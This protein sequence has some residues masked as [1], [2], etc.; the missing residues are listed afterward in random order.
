MN[1]SSE[2]LDARLM[3]EQFAEYTPDILWM[4]TAD[5]E[6]LLFINQ[7]YEDIWGGSV[8]DLETNATDFLRGVHPDYHDAILSDMER[9]SNGISIESE[10]RVNRDED[11]GRWVWVKGE[12]VFEDGTV[13]RVAGFVRDVTERHRQQEQ[14]RER[15]HVLRNIYEVTASSRPF[16]EQV[17]VLMELG[18]ETLGTDYGTLSRIRGDE[19]VFEMVTAPDDSLEAGD[20]V[21]LSAT[22]CE[23]TA[24][25]E[26]TVVLGN[27]ASDAPELTAKAG[28][29][30]WGIS[31]YLG[32]P[33]I[34]DDSVYGT[35][36]FY[37]EEPREEF[38]QWEITLV[39]LMSQWVSYELSRQ[40]ARDELVR[41]NEQLEDFASIVSHD[42]RNPLNV[43]TGRLEL[44]QDEYQSE[45]TAQIETALER[46]EA[47]I[48]DLLTL[49]Q[50]GDGVAETESLG[51]EQV[52]QQ[53]WR[54]VETGEA[55]LVVD[56]DRV[57]EADENRL[58]QLFENLVR[59]AI[60][61]G[62]E[63]V[64]IT[65][66]GTDDGFYVAD[67]GRGIPEDERADIFEPGHTTATNGTGFGLSIVEQIVEAHG[68]SVDVCESESGGARF[69]ISG[70]AAGF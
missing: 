41:Q 46:M 13:T 51:L 24:S 4:F 48:D 37:D 64:T 42:L 7:S 21:P 66:G 69:E 5:W 16:A 35:F 27:I 28:Y 30:E 58:Q 53:C 34:V 23:R 43:A 9:L 49:A 6:E 62:G 20:T 31:C 17:S 63:T 14:I 33:V 54:T 70:V 50:H 3:L 47:L 38:S 65:V 61:H 40:R 59:N 12:P 52:V 36:C 55:T 2:P 44:L 15:E 68:W 57:I 60:E 1:I 11:F 32:A 25:E 39:D 8:A 18:R 22:N 29:A 26:G 56:E 10:Y 19:Y 67:S 45:H